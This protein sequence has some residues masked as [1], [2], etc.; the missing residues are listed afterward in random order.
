MR[1]A[2]FVMLLLLV[3]APAPAHAWGYEAHHFIMDKAIALL[4]AELR[5]LFEKNRAMV[6]ERA[7]D[8]DTWRTAGFGEEPPHHFL[9]IDWEG[10]GKYPFAGLPRS[11]DEAVAKFGMDR[12]TQEG[13]LPWRTEEMYGNLRR[14]FESVGRG[15]T[16]AQMDVL[17]LSAALAHYISDAHVPLHGVSN[18]NGQLSGQI[19][20]HNRWESTMFERYRARLTIAPKPVPSIANPR[21]FVFDRILEDAQ[22][23]PALLKADADAIGNRDVY[24]DAYYE[25]FFSAQRRV[26]E[27]RLN[28]SIAAVAA[29]IAGA[30]EAAGK[31]AVPAIATPPV[32]RRRRQ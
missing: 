21:D 26:M 6:V 10:Y 2:F 32:E 20:V 14:A 4:P 11:Y 30:W 1:A 15:N 22:L 19:G 24:D 9:D 3:A 25:A 29:L 7:I 8:P 23:V 18:Y 28:K 27:D 31:P 13:T 12:I 17:L 5:P 16:F